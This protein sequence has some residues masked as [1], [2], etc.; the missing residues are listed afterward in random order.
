MKITRSDDAS[1][2]ERKIIDFPCGPDA[3]GCGS[4]AVRRVR[5]QLVDVLHL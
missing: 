3:Q 5:D 1:V 4:W 2:P